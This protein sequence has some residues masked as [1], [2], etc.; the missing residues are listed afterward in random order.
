MPR[1][2]VVLTQVLRCRAVI[3]LEV[4]FAAFNLA[5]CGVW[6]TMLVY[7]YANGGTTATALVAVAQL[8]PA[9]VLAPKLTTLLQR[10]VASAALRCGY[11]IQ[12][13]SLALLAASLLGNLSER[14]S[15]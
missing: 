11:V 13:I 7:A 5:E 6:V 1:S 12:A 14:S 2:L 8:V 3:R 4:A 9:G 15:T 10:Y